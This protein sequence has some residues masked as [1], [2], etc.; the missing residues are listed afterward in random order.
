MDSSIFSSLNR[1]IRTI[2]SHHAFSAVRSYSSRGTSRKSLFSKIAPLGNPNLSIV[3]ALD[4]W[5]DAGKTTSVAELQRIIRD[6]RKR[7][8]YGHALEVS[9]WMGNKGICKITPTDHA[10]RLDLIGKVRGSA[11]AES[12][13]NNMSEEDKTAKTYGALLNCYVRE[14]LLEKSLS[15]MQKMKQL[16][17]ASLALPYNNLM[18]LYATIGQHE[19][20][21]PVIAEMKD[22]GVLP[23]NFSYRLCTNSY[24]IRS[25]FEGM[26]KVLQEMERQSHITMDWNAY[27]IVANFYIKASFTSKAVCA[28]KKAEE[29]LLV[30]A[31][32]EGYK[33]L[34]SL[35]GNLENKTE[36]LRLWKFQNSVCKKLSNKDYI[37]IL[38]SLVKLGEF[39]DAEALLKE[40]ESSDCFYDFR[41]PN[42]LLAGYCQK[43]LIEKAEAVIDERVKKGKTPAPSSYGFIVVACVDKGEMRKAVEYMK[44]ALSV[45][46]GNEGWKP[47][48]KATA[49]ILALL[50]DGGD[51]DGT[52]TF[53]GLLN[54]VMPMNRAMYH[55]LI[56]VNILAGREVDDILDRMKTDNF[57]VDGETNKILSL[58]K[59]ETK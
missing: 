38:G 46:D 26:E 24:G 19:K 23:D 20:V 15:H 13:F 29:K 12:Y 10:V 32:A 55:T 33:H 35:Y 40:W 30:K 52:Q 11:S 41:V 22:N 8:R 48:A 1:L 5:I 28:L 31:E 18:C 21:P 43:G 3:P 53:I 16:G 17:F 45:A 4:G 54:M 7:N 51:V 39:Q 9:E 59:I 2:Q 58:R 6:L 25:D 47:N 14:R 56:K 27:C 36:M 49:K 34:I 50:G 42:V 44:A 37:T 57:E